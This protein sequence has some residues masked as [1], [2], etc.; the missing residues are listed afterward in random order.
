MSR[1]RSTIED[2]NDLTFEPIGGGRA[3]SALKVARVD[4]TIVV[5][6]KNNVVYTNAVRARISYS[7][8]GK[9]LL[10]ALEGAKKLGVLSESAVRQH[11]AAVEAERIAYNNKWRAEQMIEAAKELNLK[12]TQSQ[13]AML[14]KLSKEAA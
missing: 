14:K 6:G 13:V 11:T 1:I 5:L 7:G 4:T 9:S 12:L 3:M 10:R 2:I 8:N